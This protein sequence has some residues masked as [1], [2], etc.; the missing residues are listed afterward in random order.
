MDSWRGVGYVVT[1]MTRHGYD[2]QLTEYDG[3]H[4]RATFFVAGQA[5]AI[6]GGSAWE[7]KPWRATQRAGMPTLGVGRFTSP[8][9]P[10]HH[11]QD[12]CS[13]RAV[14]SREFE[15]F[16]TGEARHVDCAVAGCW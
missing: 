11:A 5:H 15:N 14:A 7:E 8:D 12:S 6:V 1:G 10:V 13:L 4:W 9:A 16:D 3:G 2:L